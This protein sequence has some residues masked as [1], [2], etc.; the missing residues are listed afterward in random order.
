MS[1]RTKKA[2]A[3]RRRATCMLWQSALHESCNVAAIIILILR[4]QMR[5]AV[6]P[7]HDYVTWWL[8]LRSEVLG[9]VTFSV[10]KILCT[11]SDT[12]PRTS[13][14]RPSDDVFSRRGDDACGA[15]VILDGKAVE[16]DSHA[17]RGTI[18]PSPH[19][20]S[21][22]WYQ[23]IIPDDD[24]W[25]SRRTERRI[26]YP[27]SV[28]GQFSSQPKGKKVRLTRLLQICTQYYSTSGNERVE[29]S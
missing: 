6:R 20:N 27:L 11:L 28:R 16:K 12:K 5:S 4:S 7:S 18:P 13:D 23:F 21:P 14:W 3:S 15:T 10:R 1:F 26:I 29:L 2:C 24:N 17:S 19:S 25:T 8:G 22:I 9:L